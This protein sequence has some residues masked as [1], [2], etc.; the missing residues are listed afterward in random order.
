MFN[1]TWRSFILVAG[2]TALLVAAVVISSIVIGGSQAW[3]LLTDNTAF[4]RVLLI[5]MVCQVCLHYT[6]LYDLRTIQTKR[7][8]A[9]RLMRAI[10][11]T[12]LILGIAYW[13]FPLL[14][15]EQGVFLMT[16]ALA[17]VTVMAWRSTFDVITSRLM[18]R[19]RLLL[20]GTSPA[21]IVLARELF[22]RRQ[23]LGVDIVGFVDPDPSRVGA[24]VINPGV[25]GTIDDIPGLTSRMRVDRVVVSLSDGRG[26]LPMESLLDVRLRSGV[27]FD[28]LASVYEEYTG[29][30]ALEN[31]RP[32]WLVFSTGFRKSRLLSI[33]KR[34][35]DVTAAVCGLILS[36]P[37]TII[38]AIVVKLESPRDPVLYHQER[39]GLNGATFTI[40]KF[41]TM[42]SDAEAAT[43]P[44]WSAGDSD[45]RI[46][47]VGRIMR[48]TRLD[49]IPQLV[50]VLVGQMSLIGPR[51]E[52][53]AFVEQLTQQIP[54]Y[55][56][57]HVVKPGVT[58]WAQ[59]R[60]SYGASVEDA[61]EKMQYDL[62]YVKHMSLMFDLMIALETIKTV[63]LRRGAK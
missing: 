8:L 47:R 17:I 12:S 22:E 40:H 45:P 46:T 14:V 7:D 33:V 1:K 13:L 58:G 57:R 31:L 30:I 32:S 63:V 41:R 34:A 25:V 59:V 28:H 44:V 53:P 18:P 11:A 51:P 62:Y 39:V 27:L 16:A 38:S 36:L 24:P 50:N 35:F 23:E 61:I 9:T 19:E 6:D 20:V 54:F 48:K 2:E 60:Y 37:L 4:L 5:V 56:Q 43:G 15:V 10:G 26:K 42:K 52:R 55:G 29:K 3:E 49:E 21:A